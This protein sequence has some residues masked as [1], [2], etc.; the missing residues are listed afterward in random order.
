M[1]PTA[2]KTGAPAIAAITAATPPAAMLTVVVSNLG[3]GSMT[4][5]GSVH[6]SSTDL[7]G[8]VTVF[9][10]GGH[11]SASFR[12]QSNIGWQEFWTLIVSIVKIEVH[13]KKP[14]NKSTWNHD[15]DTYIQGLKILGEDCI[16]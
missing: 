9:D 4:G 15:F 5:H 6:L 16:K 14:T 10:I 7:I 8:S 1:I 2:T 13:S 3:L 11:D 12:S